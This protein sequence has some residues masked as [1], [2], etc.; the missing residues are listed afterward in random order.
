[1]DKISL[2]ELERARSNPKVIY[3]NGKLK[4]WYYT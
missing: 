4:S 1:L 2:K 3:F